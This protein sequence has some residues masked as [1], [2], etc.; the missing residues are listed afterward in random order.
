MENN[1]IGDIIFNNEIEEFIKT[2][3]S[4]NWFNNCGNIYSE[5]LEYKFFLDKDIE[6]VRKNVTRNNNYAGIVITKNLFEQANLRL[7]NFFI[8]CG[9]Y[10]MWTPLME[11][12]IRKIKE[13]INFNDINGKYLKKIEL[14]PKKNFYISDNI[15]LLLR[16]SIMEMYCKNI[17]N[18][19]PI[20]YEKINKIYFDGHIITGWNGKLPP[21]ASQSIEPDKQIDNKKGTII[22]W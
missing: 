13:N 3:Q 16:S 1:F 20:F 5:E 14:T 7:C 17:I 10:N 19:I 2:V 12:T 9:K 22:I 6:S 15:F 4:I 18:G 21:L 11:A 8:H